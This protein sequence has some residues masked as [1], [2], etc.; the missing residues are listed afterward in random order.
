MMQLHL[1]KTAQALPFV[2]VLDAHGAPVR[3]Y[4]ERVGLPVEAIYKGTGVIGEF[5]LWRLIDLA[6]RYEKLDFFGYDVARRYPIATI[7]G[8][9]GLRM[10]NAVTL[11]ELLDLFID[12]A[13]SESTGCRYSIFHDADCAWLVRE[14]MFGENHSNWQV[15]QYM[16]TIF[17]QIIR[18]CAGPEWLPPSVKASA[19]KTAPPLPNEWKDIHFTWG[20]DD[21]R[22]MIPANVLK[23]HPVKISSQTKT[24]KEDNEDKS[25]STP[26]T[27]DELVRTQ[28]IT[29][30][31]GLE[32]AAQQTGLSPKTLKRKL[33]EANT[34]YSETLDEVR[35]K[36]ARAKLEETA[37]PI[38]II[39][40][41]LGYEH[42]ANFTRSFKRMCGLTPQEY[43][44]QSRL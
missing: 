38:T 37:T 8:L 23:K 18:L 16:I 31:I 29:N 20:N 27:F 13:Q 30:T 34:S 40:S 17:I 44:K 42:Q 7:E 32:N 22:I 5:A 39:A 14:K 26:L 12:D 3:I 15:E 2:K 35:F 6:S 41:E 9:G 24:V 25:S 36:M 33:K 4:C 43:R 21:T 1:I 11:E 10:R 28:V 19:S